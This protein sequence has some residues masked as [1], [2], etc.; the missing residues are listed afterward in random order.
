M[1]RSTAKT[2]ENELVA[3]RL[4]RALLEAMDQAVTDEDSDRSKFIRRAVRVQLQ[5]LGISGHEPGARTK[6]AA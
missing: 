6:A 3:V 4:P 1:K 5:K 2:D